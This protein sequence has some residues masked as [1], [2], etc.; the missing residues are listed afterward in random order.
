MKP[1]DITIVGGGMVGVTAALSYAQLGLRV[2]LIEAIEPQQASSPSFDQRAIALSA[3][4][5]AIYRSLGLWSQIEPVAQ[6]IHQIHVSDQ[7]Q[8]GFT[9]LKAS[10]QGVEALGEVIPLDLVGPILWQ[11]VKLQDGITTFCPAEL[12]SVT[13]NEQDCLL[14]ISLSEQRQQQIK[15]RLVIA[16]DGTFSKVANLAGIAIER[17]TYQQ[18]AIIANIQ[19]EKPHQ[20]CAYERFTSNGPL[21]L[22]PLTHN[23]MSLVWCHHV[24]EVEMV[25][26]LKDEQFLE[27]LQKAFGF[28]L[29][30]ILKV[31][32]RYQYPLSLHKA[33]QQHIGRI[34][35]LGNA[36]HTLH[37]IAGQGFN[38]GLRDI[39]M[40][41]DLLADAIVSDK[42]IGS[43]S[44][45]QSYVD[46]RVSDWSQTIVATDLLV[47]LF[48]NDCLPLAIVRNKAMNWINLSPFARQQLSHAAMGFA[49]RSSRLARGLT[50]QSIFNR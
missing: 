18:H 16:S 10:E 8:M 24:D 11:Q 29:G 12:I 9:R 38:L 25:M 21:A 45:L 32:A 35:L 26:Q 30:R 22:L 33:H 23:Q 37:P 34:V 39:A 41:N 6:P 20:N 48:S 4:S 46:S 36:A 15:A 31:S 7:G 40:L 14:T 28:R 44:F 5:V 13:N 19:T 42:E 17:N 50:N 49:G 2:A 1:F 47:R 43:Q 3:S 27:A